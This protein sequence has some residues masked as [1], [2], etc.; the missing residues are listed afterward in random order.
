MLRGI[1]FKA[2][3]IFLVTL[4]AFPAF[5][6]NRA[7]SSRVAPKTA[8]TPFMLEAESHEESQRITKTVFKN[9]LTVLVYE[10]HAQPLVSIRTYVSGGFLDDPSEM[11]GLSALT[12]RTRENVGEGS[13]AGAIRRRAQALGGVFH[14]SAEFRY[15]RFEITV[16]AARWKQAVNI[17]AEAMLAPF[18][19][20]EILRRYTARIAENARDESTPTDVIAREELRALAFGE[21]RFAGSSHPLKIDPEKIIE[22][23]KNRYILPATTL[24][25]AG[26]IRAGEVL[27]EVVRVFVL[28]SERAKNGN[29]GVAAPAGRSLKPAGEFRYRSLSGG[30]VFPKVF[31]GFPVSSVN[32]EDYRALEVTAAI[33][34]IGETSILN[35]SLRD[36]KELVFTSWAGIE[37]FGG[38]G[39]FSVELETELQNIDRTEIAFWTEVEILKRD[40][41]SE[42]ELT[43]AAAQ[44]ERLWWGRRETAGGLADALAE[45][46]FQGGWKHMDGYITEIRKITAADV[47][48]VAAR[49]LTLSNCALL[50]HLP[51]SSTERNPSA[52]ALRTTFESLLRPAMN[53]ELTARAGEIEPDFKIPSAG[54]AFRSNEIRHSFQT[55]SILRGPEI[56]IR[57]DHTS[58]LVEMGVWFTGGK[59]LEN[60]ANAGIT[61]LMLELMLRN[62]R[63]NR[64]LEIF[65]G[66][67]TPMVTDDYFGFFLSIPSRNFSGGFERIKQVIKSPVFDKSE[68]E[69]MK[70]TATARL[71]SST[72]PGEGRR[73]LNEALFRGHSYAYES[74]VTP[75]SLKNISVET[76]KDWYEENVRNVKP[77]V[78]IAGD[79]EGSSLAS[80]FVSEFSGSRMR[81]GKKIPSSPKPVGKTET[82]DYND[83]NTRPSEILLGFQ[84][85]SMGD[86]NVYGALVLKDY[87]ENR[88][89]ET[90]DI[91]GK[92]QDLETT[93]GRIS[94][95][96][97]PLL[98]GG[99]LV[100]S[101]T[102]KA[103][104]QTRDREI[105]GKE[106]ARIAA[107]PLAYADFNEARVLAAGSYMA[108][109]QTRKAQIENLTKRLLAG[110]SLEEY[111]NFPGNV[112]QVDEED[113][114]EL[115]RRVLDM[116]KASTVVV[117]Q[118]E[119]IK[120]RH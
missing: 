91:A 99:S 63:E 65:G 56:Y 74:S 19:N 103:G 60:E 78:A 119:R 97:R 108:D 52:A 64:Q 2:A 102:V 4:T 62:E 87:L 51:L 11:P 66:R 27:N 40:G 58:P 25:I 100:I 70:Q 3:I 95:E 32:S 88:L 7:P 53:E 46:E 105:L 110:R 84:A 109:N 38:A 79:T 98:S 26:D 6:Q 68:L 50:E 57:E 30:T 67:L 42:A 10:S 55:A 75:A 77:F 8:P 49:Y 72:V 44:L 47:K 96:Y 80:W 107:Q 73:R 35:T 43:R 29:T 21:S 116:D 36:R 85:P 33:L 93:E 113:F 112:E 31:F 14:G 23:H 28:K 71:R 45:S 101:T 41:P 48:R 1:G 120:I 18:E 89:R 115:M 114:K 5:G 15:S 37:S 104:T 117:P 106:I 111:Q 54:A 118:G 86:M 13:P 9:G 90:G 81:E 20:N 22:F 34:G 24:V 69:K 83:D 82:L 16:P 17:Q 12:A 39:F 59:A 92:I 61:G 76:L 94:C